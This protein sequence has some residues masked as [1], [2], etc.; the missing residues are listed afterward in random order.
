MGKNTNRSHNT[1]SVRKAVE[2]ASTSRFNP[3]VV[4]SWSKT[5]WVDSSHT[6]AS[7][8][9]NSGRDPDHPFKTIVKAIANGSAGDTIIVGSGHTETVSTAA[10]MAF[11]KAD[12]QVIGMGY[13]NR[14]PTITLDTIIGVTITVSGAGVRLE[15]LRI[16]SGFDAITALMTVTGADCQFVNLEI[17]DSATYQSVLGIALSAAADRYLIDGLKAIQLTAGATACI[18]DAGTNDGV[19]Q[20]CDIRGD[21]T[22]GAISQITA[23]L[24][25]LTLH[26]CYIRN[27][28]AD[29]TCVAFANSASTGRI[30]ECYMRVPTDA[31]LTHVDT[32][33]GD[34]YESYGVNQDDESGIILPAVS[35]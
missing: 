18:Q 33:T 4:E 25:N 31:Q 3:V 15:N 5:L 7:D 34:L 28:H 35:A 17:L 29:D 32:W 23:A 12:M 13:G 20:N 24:T 8:V 19:I 16:V 2:I 11:S 1:V 22:P 26:R 27:D 9:R 10:Q 14:R 21:Y 6:Q 30:T